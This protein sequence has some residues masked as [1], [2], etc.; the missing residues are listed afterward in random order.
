MHETRDT[1][2]LAADAGVG[3]ELSDV[4]IAPLLK[5]GA[6]LTVFATLV[7]LTVGGLFRYFEGRETEAKRSAYPLA[8]GQRDR[9]P[10]TPRLE[11]IDLNYGVNRSLPP[12]DKK[13]ATDEKDHEAVRQAMKKLANN[14][15]VRPE[16]DTRS[17]GMEPPTDSTSGRRASGVR[18]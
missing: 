2:P 13:P 6:V 16:G 7:F 9:L 8:A 4:S 12:A 18:L 1:K 15:P 11:G 14:L 10:Q 3:H 5:F 17:R